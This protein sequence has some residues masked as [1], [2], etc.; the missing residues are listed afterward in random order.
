MRQ[1][2]EELSLWRVLQG[3]RGRANDVDAL[4]DLVVTFSEIFAASPWV[5]EA[6]L[7]PVIVRPSGVGGAVAVDAAIVRSS[8]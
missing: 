2:L 3:V 5:S 7:N 1:A 8:R 6:D 4:V